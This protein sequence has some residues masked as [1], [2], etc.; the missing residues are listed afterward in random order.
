MGT[1]FDPKTLSLLEETE[2]I[3]IVTRAQDTTHKATIWIVVVDGTPYIRSFTGAKGR[4]Y[5]T[6]LANP[7]AQIKAGDTT[8]DVRATPV[9]DA[10]TIE[11]VSDAY[12]EKYRDSPYAKD[13]VR[14]EIFPTTLRLE[15]A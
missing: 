2:E 14:P 3:Q 4:W 10:K 8:I 7:E 1:K 5:Q 12:L 15:P 9:T 13:M 11:K 6:I